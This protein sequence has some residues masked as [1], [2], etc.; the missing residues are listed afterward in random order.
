MSSNGTEPSRGS[1][2]MDRRAAESSSLG[3]SQLLP[4]DVHD[5]VRP[6]QIHPNVAC[7]ARLDADDGAEDVPP[8][9][10]F[11]VGKPSLNRLVARALLHAAA[12]CPTSKG[13]RHGL[14]FRSMAA[15]SLVLHS[16]SWKRHLVARL[17]HSNI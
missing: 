7:D 5:A 4:T 1:V 9:V 17:M 3:G 2:S 12:R 11:F 10:L 14:F 6:V 13:P 15:R 16:K 8:L